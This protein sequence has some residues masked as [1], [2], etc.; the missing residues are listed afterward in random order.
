MLPIAKSPR[1]L[2]VLTVVTAATFFIYPA[3]AATQVPNPL[4]PLVRWL[5]A[6]RWEG[7]DEHGALLQSQSTATLEAGGWCVVDRTEDIDKGQVVPAAL[8]IYYWRSES[9]SLAAAG[10]NA[11]GGHGW[12]FIYVRGQDWI[13]HGS[14][15]DLEGKLRTHIDRW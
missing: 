11:Q 14:D 2:R 5:G 3:P 12:S 8:N 9:K 13:E 6:W 1:V 15:Y 7:K 4:Q 10:F